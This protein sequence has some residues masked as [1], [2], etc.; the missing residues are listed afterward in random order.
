VLT[1]RDDAHAVLGG[2]PPFAFPS[3]GTGTASVAVSREAGE[4]TGSAP[5]ATIVPIRAAESVIH[6]R[7]AELAVAVERA[8]ELGADVI[9][10][11][12][13]GV[14]YPPA[15]QEI[16]GRAVEAGTIVMAAAGQFVGP[17]VWPA[18][19]PECLG[20]G[21][22]ARGGEPWRWSS[23]GPE[24]D[25]S[26]P[27]KD[28]WVAAT[29]KDGADPFHIAQHDGTSFAVALTAGVAALW[30][31]HHG[32]RD[33]V[34][35]AVGGKPNVQAAFRALVRRE[36]TKP[37]GWD[38]ERLGAGLVNAQKLLAAKLDS[39]NDVDDEPARPRTDAEGRALDA[40]RV[41]APADVDAE[42]RM[43]A[44]FGGDRGK[45]AQFGDEVVYRM[46]EDEELRAAVLSAPAAGL[47]AG[48]PALLRAVA[49]PSLREA[50]A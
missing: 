27:A 37:D 13:G 48:G 5:R 46:A 3:H 34:A 8:V 15:L 23:K 50:L 11:S 24:V 25:I 33:S 44:L 16:I 31:A 29:R 10:I 9:T 30:L 32:G 17:V 43:V 7:N 19:F 38:T 12:M 28:V 39:W 22:S 14:L 26:A 40:A 2:F 49:S 1:D 6:V 42:A 47:E 45:L 41:M 21:G 36:C 20:V 18:R 35:D 4:I